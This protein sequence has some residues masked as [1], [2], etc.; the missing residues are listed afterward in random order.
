MSANRKTRGANTRAI[1]GGKE[2]RG[3]ASSSPLIY[4]S[5]FTFEDLE[6][7]NAAQ[8][9]GAAGSFYQRYGHPTVHAVER[10]LADLEGAEECLLF[11][12]GMAAISATFFS[13]M[14]AGD[15]A[16]AIQ[17]MYGGTFG[18]LK[19]GAERFGWSFTLVDG[20]EPETWDAAF[21]PNTKFFHVESPTNPILT[22][23]NL[24]EAARVAHRRNAWLLVDNTVASPIGQHALELGADLVLYSATKSIGGHADLMAGAVLGPREKLEEVWRARKTFGPVLDPTTAW[25]IER[26]LKTLPVR[27]EAEND[28]ALEVAMRL[29][30]HPAIA[31]VFYPGLIHHP[32]HETARQQMRHGFGPLLAF[33]VRGGS[34]A[35]ESVVNA[36]R[37]IGNGPSLGGVESLASIPALTSHVH[38]TPEERAKWGIPEGLIR[39]S[40]GLEES[41]DLWEDLEHALA[42][43]AVRVS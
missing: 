15:H 19:W 31:Q 34:A 26:S 9:S 25:Q 13:R 20:R 22:V 8:A 29:Q 38:L 24:A 41:E 43:V 4:S 40:V 27:V 10:R 14:R 30:Q 36:F 23:V 6:A 35:A 37:L 42:K 7:Q 11:A 33:D 16:V 32:M 28:N 39:L 12:S 5:T 3:G 21:R 1:H 2:T 17:Q 18:L